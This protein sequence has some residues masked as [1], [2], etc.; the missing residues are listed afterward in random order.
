MTAV[1][2]NVHSAAH[3]TSHFVFLLASIGFAVRPKNVWRFP[4]VTGEN[5]GVVEGMKTRRKPVW[6]VRNKRMFFIGVR[7]S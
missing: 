2:N 3:W 4:D 1:V 7:I 5:A 6:D